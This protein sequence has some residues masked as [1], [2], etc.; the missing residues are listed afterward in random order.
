MSA[1]TV[2]LG[3]IDLNKQLPTKNALS[4]IH[5]RLRWG[6]PTPPLVRE[7]VNFPDFLVLNQTVRSRPNSPRSGADAG[8]SAQAVTCPSPVERLP[9][10]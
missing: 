3:M 5:E 10:G 4:F 1:R 6:L 9:V 2:G 7:Y 8:M